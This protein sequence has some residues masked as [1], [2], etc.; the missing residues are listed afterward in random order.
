MDLRC[1]NTA[2]TTS[3]TRKG[4][5]TALINCADT[6]MQIGNAECAMYLYQ[7]CFRLLH[8]TVLSGGVYSGIPK[9][10][11]SR[12]TVRLVSSLYESYTERAPGSVPFPA[13]YLLQIGHTRV[14]ESMG[15]KSP[16][17][18]R[19]DLRVAGV[20]LRLLMGHETQAWGELD[21][22]LTTLSD[23]MVNH[24]H[25]MPGLRERDRAH[26]KERKRMMEDYRLELTTL[27]AVS[28]REAGCYARAAKRYRQ[29]AS[30]ESTPTEE[31]GHSLLACAR[32]Q[33]QM[34][35][36]STARRT[37]RECSALSWTGG[38]TSIGTESEETV[39]TLEETSRKCQRM[40]ARVPTPDSTMSLSLSLDAVEAA[41]NQ[42]DDMDLGHLEGGYPE[43][44]KVLFHLDTVV[45]RAIPIL[46]RVLGPGMVVVSDTELDKD[47]ID[48]AYSLSLRLVGVCA[49][50]A[51]L[52][53]M[54]RHIGADRDR[55]GPDTVKKLDT[56]CGLIT[57]ASPFR[58]GRFGKALADESVYCK[59]LL[60]LAV[61]RGTLAVEHF[62]TK[63]DAN[64]RKMEGSLDN[65][66]LA[67][68]HSMLA[69]QYLTSM[70]EDADA[71]VPLYSRVS[72]TD[73]VTPLDSNGQGI[74]LLKVEYRDVF[75]VYSDSLSQLERLHTVSEADDIV[76]SLRSLLMQRGGEE[77]DVD[78][79][80]NW[81]YHALRCIRSDVEHACCLSAPGADAS[82]SQSSQEGWL[83]LLSQSHPERWR[84]GQ[85]ILRRLNHLQP[86]GALLSLAAPV[87]TLSNMSPE[88]LVGRVYEIRVNRKDLPKL[89]FGFR[90]TLIDIRQTGVTVRKER[91][92]HRVPRIELPASATSP[93]PSSPPVCMGNG[94]MALP[95]K[96]VSV[97]G[98]ETPKVPRPQADARV[99]TA[100][101]NV[102]NTEEIPDIPM[103]M[104]MGMDTEPCP[105]PSPSPSPSP[106]LKAS[107][108]IETQSSEEEETEAEGEGERETTQPIPQTTQ[109]L[110][111]DIGVDGD[112]RETSREREAEVEA[113]S[114]QDVDMG[115]V[116]TC[117]TPLVERDVDAATECSTPAIPF[118]TEP[119]ES[120]QT[121]LLQSAITPVATPSVTPLHTPTAA[122]E[123]VNHL[124]ESGGVRVG[125]LSSTVSSR[126][127]SLDATPTIT[128]RRVVPAIP[129]PVTTPAGMETV[130][131]CDVEQSTSP[132]ESVHSRSVSPSP[133]SMASLTQQSQASAYRCYPMPHPWL[134]RAS[135]LERLGGVASVDA[136]EGRSV[137]EED[138]PV[139]TPTATGRTDAGP[140]AVDGGT[141]VGKADTA[142][143]SWFMER[144]QEREREG[145]GP[146]K[147][148]TSSLPSGMA[149]PLAEGDA[150]ATHVPASASPSIRKRKVSSGDS[151]ETDK[152]R[153]KRERAA[154]RA[155]KEE[156]RSQR[157]KRREAR[158]LRKIQGSAV[159]MSMSMSVASP[160]QSPQRDSA[161]DEGPSGRG[162]GEGESVSKVTHV[163]GTPRHQGSPSR[164]ACALPNFQGVI[165]VFQ[166]PPRRDIPRSIYDQEARQR[167]TES[168]I[169]IRVSEEVSEGHVNCVL[170]DPEPSGGFTT[171]GEREGEGEGVYEMVDSDYEGVGTEGQGEGVGVGV[172]ERETVPQNQGPVGLEHTLSGVH[173]PPAKRGMF[174]GSLPVLTDPRK[175]VSTT[176]LYPHAAGTDT[177]GLFGSGSG[178]RALPL[179]Q[180]PMAGGGDMDMVVSA[181]PI[182]NSADSVQFGDYPS[183]SSVEGPDQYQRMWQTQTLP[184]TQREPVQGQGMGQAVGHDM[185][186]VQQHAGQ[187][188]APCIYGQ[189]QPQ[190]PHHQQQQQQQFC[191][192]QQY[193]QQVHPPYAQPQPQPPAVNQSHVNESHMQQEP[194]QQPM[195]MSPPE[196]P[197]HPQGLYHH[198]SVPVHSP[199]HMDMGQ[200]PVASMQTHQ[201]QHQH[202]PSMQLQQQI[203]PMEQQQ[204][205]QHQQHMPPVEQQ[206]Q[207]H[208][209]PMQ[210]QQMPPM[211]QGTPPIYMHQQQQY[212]P[213][214][215][216]P[217][218][219]ELVPQPTSYAQPQPVPQQQPT[220]NVYTPYVPTTPGHG[221]Y[222]VTDVVAQPVR[223]GSPPRVLPPRLTHGDDYLDRVE[224]HGAGPAVHDPISE[225][226]REGQPDF[227]SMT[228]QEVIAAISHENGMREPQIRSPRTRRAAMQGT[229][230]RV[231]GGPSGIANPS[232]I[233]GVATGAN[234]VGTGVPASSVQPVQTPQT[235][236]VRTGGPTTTTTSTTS[237]KT[238]P[239]KRSA[240]CYGSP[241]RGALAVPPI[242]GCYNKT[243]GNPYT[244]LA[245]RSP[246]VTGR[247]GSRVGVHPLG[248][249]PRAVKSRSVPTVH[250]CLTGRAIRLD[251]VFWQR[252]Q[253]D[254]VGS[255]EVSRCGISVSPCV[256]PDCLQRLEVSD[257]QLDMGDV[258][259]LLAGIPPSLSEL[260]LHGVALRKKGNTSLPV[261]PTPNL[262][263]PP[264]SLNLLSLD[265]STLG[266][267]SQVAASRL[268]SISHL[269]LRQ[270]T[271]SLCILNQLP[272]GCV[273]NV[274]DMSLSEEAELQR[275]RRNVPF[276]T[277]GDVPTLKREREEHRRDFLGAV[278][279]CCSIV[280]CSVVHSSQDQFTLVRT[281]F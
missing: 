89:S 19:P 134:N 271:G 79:D 85:Q 262:G 161:R 270:C 196:Y 145:E 211:P 77:V 100:G 102:A 105:S 234:A 91:T 10:Q 16:K 131:I 9:G 7:E 118:Q 92:N 117:P 268:A 54:L 214:T 225:G 184:E 179:N 40:T 194:Q 93:T 210:H 220:P 119:S 275:S 30:W 28:L 277:A 187:F 20:K 27:Y 259:S 95:E 224:R 122:T 108:V 25:A 256:L 205:Q 31:R 178:D 172:R 69:R 269:S 125:V 80:T 222:G 103:D 233:T 8:V 266:P 17:V 86:M 254:N 74:G 215:L 213:S 278:S 87:C 52:G 175:A 279:Q 94:T 48:T 185:G 162:S 5:M 12:G 197:G 11:Y 159:S 203:P 35:S 192:Q 202:L 263:L 101:V 23:A 217:H 21:S 42:L 253:S 206:H 116:Q 183:V 135:R 150:S 70:C 26:A 276:P 209:P 216:M 56:M 238:K 173:S 260:V 15:L 239:V 33:L 47:H 133:S 60:N 152:Q 164:R 126:Q 189:Q 46:D 273:T 244:R 140:I 72:H 65:A 29:M 237:G 61:D 123:P 55:L 59:A 252:V 247:S 114:T 163:D 151:P 207:Q 38:G 165:P 160:V 99:G 257:C 190:H 121:P 63:L 57:P 176:H 68:R 66:L 18:S 142:P 149:S 264:L 186:Y 90:Y 51:E 267:L 166:S 191:Q 170:S 223:K 64:H 248:Q 143:D 84:E 212:D 43:T 272:R 144:A 280:S 148:V 219:T 78:A 4:T 180:S 58:P 198:Q 39:D 34:G 281:G 120:E 62:I 243:G 250:L 255:L 67:V 241:G 230:G 229:P 226:E 208:I 82:I 124:T 169:P 228:A 193:G 182:R 88:Y 36:Y 274:C 115:Q 75:S 111:G 251:S 113:E 107:R 158:A 97:R 232:T 129:S 6:F 76:P 246:Y 137:G 231:Y 258:S 204:H 96:R 127:S 106:G 147:K 136:T 249:S 174:G 14:S 236:T 83:T 177:S 188:G 98:S 167:G 109:E 153:R 242:P 157:R 218:P 201:H 24:T 146:A 245:E 32:C 50:I 45:T 104:D 199:T 155:L 154:K 240:S 37:L 2:E 141:A 128:V 168:T 73:G 261:P 235:T 265:G 110:W 139:D 44:L 49:W 138:T 13:P 132:T 22:Y 181:S 171:Q 3:Y 227:G 130:S 53:V 71:G 195:A 1:S 200:A 41:F 81:W 112:E 221:L 156:R